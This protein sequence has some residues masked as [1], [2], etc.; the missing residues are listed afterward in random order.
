MI[1]GYAVPDFVSDFWHYF[2]A[3]I[4]IVSIIAIA[5]FLR[6]QTTRKLAPGEK[7]E[8]ME[9]AWDGD[10]QELNNPL[11]RW[12][13]YGFWGLIALSVI[14]LILYPGL[15][16]FAGT[17]NWSSANQFQSEKERLDAAFQKEFE[18]FRNLDVMAVAADPTA[19]EMGKRLYLTYCMQCHGSAGQGSRD[20]P[21]L[22]DRLWLFG[23]DPDSIRASIASGRLAEMPANM[24][25]DEAS[26]REV[27]HHVLALGGKPHDA[28]LAAAGK[29]KYAACAGCHGEDGKG[30]PAA[31]FPDLTDDA[32][33]Y[34]GSAE[35]IVASIVQGRKG[36]MPAFQEMLGD[37]KIHLLTAYVWG[38][39]RESPAQ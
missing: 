16:K 32:W 30:M 10:L 9:H 20:F 28:A 15:G 14:Y 2:I 4:T 11:P 37:D 33:M 35:E 22:T 5:W 7:A 34:G 17:W 38:M 19:M 36:G 31:S 29:D 21:A 27:A 23:G 25:G 18:P 39:G 1:A 12:W 3:G 8:L 6:S 26:S 13:L 24:L